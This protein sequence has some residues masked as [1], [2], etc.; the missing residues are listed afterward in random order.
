MKAYTEGTGFDLKY[1]VDNYPW[2]NFPNGTVV[3][4]II[5]SYLMPKLPC[6]D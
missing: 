6:T 1:V 3:D 5:P 4:V 2:E